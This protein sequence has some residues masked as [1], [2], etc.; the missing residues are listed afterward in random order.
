MILGSVKVHAHDENGLSSVVGEATEGEPIGEAALLEGGARVTSAAV[1]SDDA[2]LGLLTI[3]DFHR[4]A[5]QS[6]VLA[7][8]VVAQLSLGCAPGEP[9]DECGN[10]IPFRPVR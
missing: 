6:T 1:S 3:D 4:M 2:I 5:A 9:G 8:K 7:M 10:V